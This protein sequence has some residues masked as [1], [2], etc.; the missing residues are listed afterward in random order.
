MNK[1]K[2]QLISLMKKQPFQI[3]D[4]NNPSEDIIMAALKSNP[5]VISGV[6]KPNKKMQS[7]A[8]NNSSTGGWVLQNI[9]DKD[10]IREVELEAVKKDGS[11]ISLIKNPTHEMQIIAVTQSS[12]NLERIRNK[13]C[14]A[15]RDICFENVRQE[16]F[17]KHVYYKN[18]EEKK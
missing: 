2:K 18:S 16:Y 5:Y 10:R 4:I 9:K 17:N 13:V 14:D 7:F 15:A 12:F 11:C 8:I 6:K 3:R 1:Y